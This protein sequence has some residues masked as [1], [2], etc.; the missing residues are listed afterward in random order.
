MPVS[1]ARSVAVP[2][3]PKKIKEIEVKVSSSL[4]VKHRYTAQDFWRA[5]LL[6]FSEDSVFS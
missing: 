6:Y 2:I 4:Q 5:P 3:V 1:D